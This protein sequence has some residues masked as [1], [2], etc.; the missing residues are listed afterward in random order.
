M[1]KS[2]M[3]NLMFDETE[4]L[5]AELEK[6]TGN[7]TREQLK[8]SFKNIFASAVNKT[9]SFFET[10]A[11]EQAKAKKEKIL[12]WNPKLVEYHAKRDKIEVK[13]KKKNSIISKENLERI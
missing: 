7:L 11:K 10:R 8:N 6:L 5:E 4:V 3:Q 2:K 9:K 13:T 12:T 1:S